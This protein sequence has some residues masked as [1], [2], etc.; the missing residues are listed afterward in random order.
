[1]TWLLTEPM[2]SMSASREAP[3]EFFR[4]DP[5][6]NAHGDVGHGLARTASGWHS[7]EVVSRRRPWPRRA[8]RFRPRHL[9][10]EVRAGE[11]LA[12]PGPA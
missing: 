8:A 10:R 4:R 1:M 12:A 7:G 2:T 11:C 9:R 5:S 3:G 6:G